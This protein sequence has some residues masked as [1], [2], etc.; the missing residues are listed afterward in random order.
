MKKSYFGVMTMELMM[1][2]IFGLMMV[3]VSRLT[4]SASFSL[5]RDVTENKT[6]FNCTGYS[7]VPGDFYGA[8]NLTYRIRSP[9]HPP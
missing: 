5:P 9:S 6:V 3:V 4:E 8:N 2:P 7:Q 1:S